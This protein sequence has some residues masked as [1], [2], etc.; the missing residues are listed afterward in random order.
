MA[1]AP[2]YCTTSELKSFV[3]IG[4]AVDDAQVA[5]AVSAASRAVDQATSRQFGLVD[6]AEARYYAA[7]YDRNLRRWVVEID[8]LM[9]TTSMTVKCDLG[10]D[11]VYD[12]TITDFVLRPRNASATARP[13]T[14]LVVNATSVVQPNSDFDGVRVTARYGWTAVPQAIKEATLLQ[15][16]RI[17]ARRNAPFGVAGA[18]EIGS[19]VRLLARVDPDVAVTVRPYVRMWGAR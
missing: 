15:A 12:D 17:L 14:E 3:R 11:G 13:W 7:A 16:S 18:P 2:D 10:D 8:D 19:E 6:T 5:L 9:T 1:W 4:D